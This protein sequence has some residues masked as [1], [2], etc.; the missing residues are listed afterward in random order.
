MDTEKLI[1]E[2]RAEHKRV[3]GY[4]PEVKDVGDG[5]LVIDHQS[6]RPA[7][8]AGSVRVETLKACIPYYANMPTKEA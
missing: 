7:M 8:Q 4:S 6:G 3:Y 5:W 1:A 2:Y